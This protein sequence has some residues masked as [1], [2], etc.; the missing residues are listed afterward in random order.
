MSKLSFNTFCIEYYSH[1]INKPSNEV[2]S[3]FKTSGLLDLINEDYEDLHGMSME[4]LM[5]FFDDYFG[6]GKE[7]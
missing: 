7:K 3:I 2:Y 4:Y 5:C 1:H 6:G